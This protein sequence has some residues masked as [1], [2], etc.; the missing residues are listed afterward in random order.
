MPDESSPRYALFGNTQTVAWEDEHGT[1]AWLAFPTADAPALFDCRTPECGAAHFALEVV[2]PHTVERHYIGETG[3]LQTLIQTPSGG[4]AS[5]VD[6]LPVR[7]VTTP[8]GF[9][10]RVHQQRLVRVVEA[11]A[12]EVTFQLR[13]APRPDGVT[14]ETELDTNGLLFIGSSSSVILQSEAEVHVHTGGATG[15]F[16]LKPQEKRH[17]V[18]T[19]VADKDPDV[20]EIRATEAD[21]EID[22]TIDY[23]LQW[24]RQC[25]F[26]GVQRSHVLKL[27]ALLK[28][29]AAPGPHATSPLRMLA[30][31]ALT[32]WGWEQELA[33]ALASWR[34]DPAS[35]ADRQQAGW[36]LWG[37]ATAQAAGLIEATLV[38]PHWSKLQPMVE[39]LAGATEPAERLAVWVGLEGGLALAD[40]LLLDGDQP[41]W[42]AAREALRPALASELSPAE[43]AAV[44]VAAPVADAPEGS[45]AIERCWRVRQELAAGAY[46]Q[47]RRL[48]DQLLQA[49]GPLGI[50]EG[51][52][53][54]H[55][56]PGELA[57]VL[58]TAAEIYLQS[59]PTPGKV[60]LPGDLGD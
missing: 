28:A 54:A 13:F 59:A 41:A 23:W 25:P 5:M 4:R 45:E 47:A 52:A 36:L 19:Q 51:S 18:I 6:F 31:V 26:Q 30:P 60:N 43:A 1:I 39:A 32:A 15:Q 49:Y 38:V 44:G 50:V 3:I 58:W 2:G 17:F 40:E 57:L 21:W 12:G 22:G 37:L 10:A 55:A 48:M 35:A 24:G 7:P 11:H 20:P 14:P 46:L 56:E 33:Q 16:T 8:E 34:P 53:Q 29:I 42:T 27:A 9:Q